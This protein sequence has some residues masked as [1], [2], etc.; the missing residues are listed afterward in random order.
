[1]KATCSLA[2]AD[3]VCGAGRHGHAAR[4]PELE[5]RGGVV[6]GENLLYGGF[7]GLIL[8][9]N[10][11]QIGIDTGQTRGKAFVRALSAADDA[12]ALQ[13]EDAGAVADDTPAHEAG[14]GVYADDCYH[15]EP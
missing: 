13:T 10:V 6:G 14:T 5:G 7:R 9:D 8:P 15:R 3:A 11:V 1:M 4:L 12:A 2:D